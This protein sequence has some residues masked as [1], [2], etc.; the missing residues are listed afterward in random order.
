MHE[1]GLEFQIKEECDWIMLVSAYFDESGKYKD[2]DLVCFGGV[3]SYVKDFTDFGH[4]WARLL[5]SSGLHVLHTQ[6][7]LKPHLPFGK[8]NEALGVDNRIA[9]L[10]PFIACIR[11]HLQV[12]TGLAFDAKSF[13]NLPP[14]LFD[15][16]GGDPNYTAFMRALL[17]VLSFTHD[18]D[19]ISVICDD[20]ESTAWTFYKLYRRIKLIWP[21][22][23][24]KLVALT[25][26]DD[27][28]M[29]GL[30]A[31]DLVSSLIRLEARLMLFKEPY[32]YQPLFKALSA[33]PDHKHE[34]LWDMGIAIVKENTLT[35]AAEEL[36]KAWKE[37]QK[38]N[39][40]Q[41]VQKIRSNDEPISKGSPRR[42]KSKTRRGK[43]SEKEK[44]EAKPSASGRAADGKD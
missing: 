14:H 32:D 5:H 16:M 12:I 15:A 25:F 9:A 3:S 1:L 21:G 31:S 19:H 4:E 38:K 28:F 42:D 39:E 27:K 11:K 34:R 17:R 2:H 8:K 33:D 6:R 10:L 30:Q 18:G 36:H 40:E 13:R 20:E 26:G 35:G 29:F 41:R 22:A 37:A 43:S 7:A 23:R 24:K 44:A